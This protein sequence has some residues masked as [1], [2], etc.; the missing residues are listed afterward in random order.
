MKHWQDVKAGKITENDLLI[1]L[2]V[3]SEQKQKNSVWGLWAKRS[4]KALVVG[5]PEPKQ[6]KR[7]FQPVDQNQMDGGA[8][9]KEKKEE[10]E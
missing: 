6:K 2:R 10:K 8:A 3:M 5:A 9:H 1:K 4:S 7:L